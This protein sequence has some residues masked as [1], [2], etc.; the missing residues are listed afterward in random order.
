MADSNSAGGG[1]AADS[2]IG[3]LISLTSKSEIRYE[4]IL[5]TVDTANSNIALQDVRSFG[6]EGRKKDGPQIPSSDKVYDYIIFRGTDIKDLQ[7]K[8]SPPVRPPQS[9]QPHHDPAIISLQSQTSP[10]APPIAAGNIPASAAST[11]T[12]S[13]A[14]STTDGIN[15]G[16]Y[17]SIPS[18]GYQANMPPLYQPY[19]G[20]GSWAMPQIPP[21]TN[22]T[23]GMPMYWP[24]YYRPP[25]GISHL[26]QQ[27]PMPFQGPPSVPGYL[28]QSRSLTQQPLPAPTSMPTSV[29]MPDSS[30]LT[31][32]PLSTK[33]SVVISSPDLAS[34]NIALPALSS[35][36]QVSTPLDYAST[37]ALPVGEEKATAAMMMARVSPQAMAPAISSSHSTGS[38][39]G[40]SSMNIPTTATALDSTALLNPTKGFDVQKQPVIFEQLSE[41]HSTTLEPILS[42]ASTSQVQSS[43]NQPLLPLL[44]LPVNSVRPKQFNQGYGLHANT[45]YM[46]RGRGRGRGIGN[47]QS[48]SQFM[49]DF[50][51]T[52][53]NEKFNKDE[54]WGELGKADFREKGE[55]EEDIPEHPQY[56]EEDFSKVAP[57][58]V[59]DDFFDTL[60]CDTFD[61]GGQVERTKFSE[62]RKIDTETFGRFSL[63]SRGG[64]GGRGGYRGGSRG[65]GYYAGGR[66]AGN[67]GRGRSYARNPS[68]Y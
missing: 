28:P 20:I 63:R 44:P 38:F 39:I 43:P 25:S 35:A 9:Q 19:A 26:Q 53:M 27:S 3:S 30:Q 61:R 7:V 65:G 4:G 42:T 8:S 52:A 41:E 36:F 37:S 11:A 15:P 18:A 12:A 31:S 54:V 34:S 2:Y 56:E 55:G 29:A 58:Y 59:K 6:T 17:S 10:M 24:G 64:R 14:G 1:G 32:L 48:H 13:A 57:V 16:P 66:L 22:G 33:D 45:M 49:E 68:G 51:F 23:M 50:D 62:Q 21:G 67:G 46:R 40:Q 60:S 5:Y 47:P